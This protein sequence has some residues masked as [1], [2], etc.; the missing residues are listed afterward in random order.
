[1]MMMTVSSLFKHRVLRYTKLTE[2][3]SAVTLAPDICWATHKK[4]PT[5][6]RRT[7]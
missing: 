7:S 2:M 6:S 3:P 1:M 5:W 4:S